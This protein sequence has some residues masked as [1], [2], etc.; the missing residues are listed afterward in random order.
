MQLKL[1]TATQK[2]ADSQSGSKM[3][4]NSAGNSQ[5]YVVKKGDTFWN[6]SQ[7]FAVSEK[8]IRDVN[9]IPLKMALVLGQKLTIKTA[10]QQS[11]VSHMVASAG[12]QLPKA[13]N[14]KTA[15]LSVVNH[16]INYTV[17]QG[18]SLAQISRKFN[19]SIADL[20][21]WNPP[22]ISNALT[23]GK[24]LKVILNT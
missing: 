23:P 9:K 5:I 4:K 14:Q 24:K 8:D 2:I 16:S 11:L 6:V 12:H 15:P 1:P 21:K 13:V 10:N 20:R 17:K 19:V 22:E 7:K 18:D 3:V